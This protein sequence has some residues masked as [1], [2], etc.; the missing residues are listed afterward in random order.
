MSLQVCFPFT[1]ADQSLYSNKGLGYVNEKI[2]NGGQ[3]NGITG[4]SFY[5]PQDSVFKLDY[6]DDQGIS[7]STEFSFCTWVNNSFED[8]P[9][10]TLLLG[11]KSSTSDI[12]QIRLDP[13]DQLFLYI[14]STK[15]ISV[16]GLNL[17][18]WNH[19]VVTFFEG[20]ISI[21]I[22]GKKY[23]KSID[24]SKTF[25][26][27]GNYQFGFGRFN[28]YR[29]YNHCLSTAEIKELSKA[30]IFHYKLDATYIAPSYI[31][32]LS[33]N[34]YNPECEE[35][36]YNSSTQLPNVTSCSIPGQYQAVDQE[37]LTMYFKVYS[38][39]S[40]NLFN[41]DNSFKFSF[42]LDSSPRTVK[43]K[44]G[45][46]ET[47]I[48]SVAINGNLQNGY[49]TF[50]LTKDINSQ[51]ILWVNN[52]RYQIN[53]TPINYTIPYDISLDATNIKEMAFY[54]RALTPSDFNYTLI[55]D[56][57]QN[58]LSGEFVEQGENLLAKSD[59]AKYVSYDESYKPII[60]RCID[61]GVLNEYFSKEGIFESNTKYKVYLKVYGE[62]ETGS[63]TIY[64][65][66]NGE[67]KPKTI[68]INAIG[69]EWVNISF[70][71]Y[72]TKIEFGEGSDYYYFSG[73][74]VITK[75]SNTPIINGSY[76][77]G[78][79]INEGNEAQITKTSIVGK[80]LIEI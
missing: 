24:I 40:I 4:Q 79:C 18:Q 56:N 6:S 30:K 57:K 12:I 51:F 5:S 1:E 35:I 69:G 29:I 43:L 31:Q 39:S 7:T 2:F 59:L 20:K 37:E 34:G 17:F 55:V 47:E 61:V 3:T 53:D 33:F 49:N 11:H 16:S 75:S 64:Y 26:L 76:T 48:S 66:E 77:G 36:N 58:I 19:I 70:D 73:D 15:S 62:Y 67:L 80:N 44:F 23:Q 72:I 9:L 41:S 60:T 50:L 78:V 22:N 74:S 13:N 68:D 27:S 21:Y 46:L 63:I 71:N 52:G 54:S 42:N 65:N 14:N 45:V 38:G 25:D 28:D 8:Q 32:D 10:N